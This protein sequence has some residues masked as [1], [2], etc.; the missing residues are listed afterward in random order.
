MRNIGGNPAVGPDMFDVMTTMKAL[1][2]HHRCTVAF[3][4]K[5]LR[6]SRNEGVLVSVA[7][8]PTVAGLGAGSPTSLVV[9]REF[10][11]NGSKNLVAHLYGMLLSLDGCLCREVWK[12]DT[13]A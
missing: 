8:T 13:F 6:M 12:Q 11:G 2:S 1:E 7:A 5:P 4:L 3:E 10:P 9:I